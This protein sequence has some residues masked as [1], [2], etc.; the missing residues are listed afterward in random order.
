MKRLFKRVLKT[1]RVRVGLC[2]L[3]AQYIRF[4]H[5]TGRWS[6]LNEDSPNRVHEAGGS[7]V[8]AF[9]HGRLLMMA[10]AWRHRHR[11]KILTSG[12][13]DGR[14]V[15]MTMSHFGVDSVVGSTGKGGAAA[16]V[17]LVRELRRGT[18]I[19]LTPDGPRGPRMRA[20]SGFLAVAR[21][22]RVPIIPLTM[23]CSRAILLGSWDRFMVPLPF[24]RG[25]FVW[26]EPIHIPPDADDAEMERLR[27]RL[28][29][30]ITALQNR[31]DSMMGR[32]LVQ[33][34]PETVSGVR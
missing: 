22:A 11:V 25:V 7:F 31:G 4:V 14:M 26:G 8:L 27:R 34:T 21:I 32:A 17:A 33:P 28:E 9:W 3:A 30:E 18:V 24:A 6:V 16:V 29:D 15:G 20:G 2:W 19:G 23:S 13:R 12:H 10:Y 1:E 5:A